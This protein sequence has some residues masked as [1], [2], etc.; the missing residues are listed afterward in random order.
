MAPRVSDRKS[1]SITV[2][3]EGL[4]AKL[5]KHADGYILEYVGA[6]STEWLQHN[7]V[8]PVK[9]PL[10]G[11]IYTETVS[12]LDL[13]LICWVGMNGALCFR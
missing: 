12:V 10:S 5:M 1:D 3:W 7:D 4:D 8:I 11:A 6:G 2:L 9:G 13:A